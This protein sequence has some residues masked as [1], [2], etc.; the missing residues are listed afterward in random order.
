MKRSELAKLIKEEVLNVLNEEP[1]GF[2]KYDDETGKM[3]FSKYD[4]DTTKLP[5]KRPAEHSWSAIKKDLK[6]MSESE[7]RKFLEKQ[8][9]KDKE[10]VSFNTYLKKWKK[11][12]GK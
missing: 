4:N 12:V 11:L 2:D 7:F 6:A 8:Y 1:I 3:G 10:T 9:K 5:K